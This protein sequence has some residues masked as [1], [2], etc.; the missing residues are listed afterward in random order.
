MADI[1]ECPKCSKKG[2]VHR[3]NDLYQCL[4][5]DFKRDLSEPNKPPQAEFPWMLAFGLLFLLFILGQEISHSDYQNPQPA[6]L[7][8]PQ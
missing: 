7:T 8:Y 5:C 2:L 3:Q 1:I 4:I 6:P